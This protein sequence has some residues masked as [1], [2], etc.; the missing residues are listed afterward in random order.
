MG[1]SKFDDLLTQLGTGRW[2]L[3][4]FAII[5]W[6]IFF[7]P[8][9]VLSIIFLAPSM[10]YSCKIPEEE[11]EEE[12]IVSPQ[13][14]VDSCSYVVNSSLT[15]EQ[16]ERL[17]TDW[18][19]DNTTYIS[20]LTSQFQLVCGRNY[21]RAVYHGIF[22]FGNVCGPPIAG[23]FSD[24]YGRKLV[25]MIGGVVFA[26]T[27]LI[28]PL[29]PNFTVLLVL[30]FLQGFF[31][32]PTGYILALEVCEPSKRSFVGILIALPW[33]LGTMAFGGFAYFI[34]DWHW[35]Q[36]ILTFPLALLIPGIW[37]LDESPRW[38]IVRGYH[39]RA[40][41]ILQ[42]AARWNKVQLPTDSQ[43]LSIMRDIQHE[44]IVTSSSKGSA[45]S[46]TESEKMASNRESIKNESK[47]SWIFKCDLCRTSHIRI[48]TLVMTFIF[49]V[50]ALVFHGLALSAKDFSADVFVYVVLGGLTEVPAYSVSSIIVAKYG[51]RIPLA[52][53]YSVCGIALLV[54][55]IIPKGTLWLVILLAMIGKLGISSASQIIYLYLSELYPTEYRLQGLGTA[56]LTQRLGSILAPLIIQMLGPVSWWA[57]S[58]VMG[59]LSLLAG[60]ATLALPETL[61]AV[62]PDTL[63]DLEEL[64]ANKKRKRAS[65]TS[66]E[67]MPMCT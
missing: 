12:G 38:L 60:M 35:L 14:L 5:C 28:L 50:S 21:L 13:N 63:A 67:M 57:P 27:A 61:G 62:L 8:G 3:L 26:F 6:Y 52:L 55:I 23:V 43:L 15:G 66:K 22:M 41:K 18:E 19:F 24:K 65:G 32:L 54:L 58:V 11:E 25:A 47:R 53:C 42:K 16:E 59:L 34:R 10:N 49:F 40:L 29:I 56:V 37:L 44:S 39:E 36:F 7:L 2:N 9:Q 20:T 31:N 1:S 17:C 64:F 30:R 48:I 51:R 45:I 46:L 4:Y 33:A